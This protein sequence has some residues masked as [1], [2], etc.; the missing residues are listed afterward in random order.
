MQVMELLQ[1]TKITQRFEIERKERVLRDFTASTCRFIRR[2]SNLIC[3]I[4]STESK[5]IHLLLD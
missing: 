1:K 2:G 4:A 3:E 5:D